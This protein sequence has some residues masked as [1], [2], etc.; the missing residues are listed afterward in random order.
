MLLS[1]ANCIRVAGV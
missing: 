1:V